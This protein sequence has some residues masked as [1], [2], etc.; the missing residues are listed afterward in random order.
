MVR[1]AAIN[2]IED[3]VDEDGLTAV[4]REYLAAPFAQ[5]SPQDRMRAMQIKDKQTAHRQ[6]IKDETRRA[7]KE[8]E[9]LRLEEAAKPSER[10]RKV[11]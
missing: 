11:H 1:L 7:E 4:E 9:K 2:S 10:K 5:L 6:S 8:K 3:P